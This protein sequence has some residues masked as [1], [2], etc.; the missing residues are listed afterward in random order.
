M[1]KHPKLQAIVEFFS[2]WLRLL[3]SMRF[4]NI[5]LALVAL[6]SALSSL[7]PQGRELP[8]Y[9]E[10]YADAYR[11]IYRTHFYDV[12]KSWYFVLIMA[13]L[14]LSLLACTIRMLLR[15]VKGGRN[16][17]ERTAA[18]PNAEKLRPGELE[19]LRRWAASRRCREEKLGDAYVFRKNELGRWGVFLL[20]LS[21][22][23][24]VF[25][26][27][28]A[29]AL[30]K[31]TDVPCCPG[32]T[33]ELRDGSRITVDSFTMNNPQGLLDYTS[34]VRVQLPDGRESPAQ[35]V[36][37]NYPLTFG[38]VKV[39][40]WEYGYSGSIVA[41]NPQTGVED[42]IRLEE[43]G[44]LLDESGNGLWYSDIKAARD[45]AD[46]E[47]ETILVYQIRVIGSG[48]M[49]PAD[50]LVPVGESLQIGDWI[51][52]FEDPYYPILR[53]KQ[54]PFP[55]AN[56]LLEGAFVLLLLGLFLCF[57]LQPVLIRAD[58]NGYTVAGPRPEKLRLELKRLLEK[59][60]EKQ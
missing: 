21:I 12:F 2:P 34:V 60:G 47:G 42:R 53:I 32:Q 49:M 13:L 22:L 15:A 30:P 7:L 17:A 39:F 35:E 38:N 43:P 11:L 57:F 18:L 46:P 5:L 25:F 55:Y 52:S 51:Y 29:L 41:R 50:T 9:A 26:G 16:A 14:C 37:V 40:Q 59:E 20:H 23:L 33:V 36:K 10:H 3:L 19:E 24:T 31:V 8:F 6:L 27:V 45:T 44:R 54:M 48:M 1:K 56:S 28:F 58:E 4:A